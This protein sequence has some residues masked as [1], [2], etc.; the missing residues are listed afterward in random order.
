MI[1]LSVALIAHNEEANMGGALASVAWAEQIVVVDCASTDRTAEIA[2][3]HSAVLLTAPNYPNLNINKNLAIDACNGDWILVL[4]ADEVV[5]DD[6]A[7]EIRY[8]INNLGYS[9]YFIP[10]RNIVLGKW[11]RYGGQYPD[12]QLRL[13]KRGSGR[14][15]ARHV[16]E[17]LEVV[18][19][20]GR[21]A[22]PLEHHPYPSIAK[23]MQKSVFYVD[24]EA[25][26]LQQSGYPI[27]TFN[28]LTQLLL[29]SPLRFCRRYILKGGFLD[30]IPGLAA[31]YFDQWNQTV[32]WLKLWDEARRARLT[33]RVQS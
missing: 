31:A 28:L 18:G 7:G 26:F 32:R 15:P 25:D 29:K 13:F 1:R 33:N 3:T 30:G 22:R 17:R 19:R 5:S 21:L 24:F 4:D 12:W 16:H 10:R 11:L 6:L 20:I 27:S 9:G 8:A 2:R 23:M 14:F